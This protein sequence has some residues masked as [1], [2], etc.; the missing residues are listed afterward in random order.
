MLRAG[1]KK[2]GQEEEKDDHGY[3]DIHTVCYALHRE[4]NQC[5]ISDCL[6]E[7][8]HTCKWNTYVHASLYVSMYVCMYVCMSEN[9]DTYT[10]GHR[11]L[12]M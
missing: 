4:G 7:E 6:Y 3:V 8:A 10:H 12:H 9:E 11:H 2:K 5:N 1:H